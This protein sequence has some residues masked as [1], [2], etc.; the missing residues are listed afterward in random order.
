MIPNVSF[1]RSL[2]RKW[3]RYAGGASVSIDNNADLDGFDGSLE[4]LSAAL[5]GLDGA[6]LVAL[7]Q[8]KCRFVLL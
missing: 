6:A 8:P 1:L 5:G 4:S 2:T 7:G 3:T